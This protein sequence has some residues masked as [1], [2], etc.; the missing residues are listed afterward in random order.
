MFLFLWLL[1][2]DLASIFPNISTAF[3]TFCIQSCNRLDSLT[4]RTF[5]KY[6]NE[7][8]KIQNTIFFLEIPYYIVQ[9]D[10]LCFSVGDLLE[11]YSYVKT[12]LKYCSLYFPYTVNFILPALLTTYVRV[13]ALRGILCYPNCRLK[14]RPMR[15]LREERGDLKICS[16][17]SNVNTVPNRI[18][19]KKG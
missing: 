11:L 16:Y 9:N 8:K 2:T 10:K 3:Q 4:T 19:R 5:P 18:T 13:H 14:F 15:Q 1:K 12:G 7:F 17:Y 6:G